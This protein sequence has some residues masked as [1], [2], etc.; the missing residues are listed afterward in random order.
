MSA[1]IAEEVALSPS[2]F[3]KRFRS[4]YETPLPSSNLTLPVQKRYRDTSKLILDTNSEGDEVEQ[5]DTKEDEKDECPGMEEEEKAAPEG[6]QQAVLVVNI[7]ASEPLGLGYG[8]ARR[9]AFESIEE[10]APSTY[11]VGQ[12]SRSVLEQEGVER[13]SA[14]RQPTLVTWVDLEDG[15][16]YTNIL[17]YAPPAAPVQTPPSFDWSLDSLPVSP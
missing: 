5:E 9:R 14:F 16:V 17:T 13:I 3:R 8:T 1:R 12:G 10:I 7:A 15:R 2:S 11:E 4:P 6:Q